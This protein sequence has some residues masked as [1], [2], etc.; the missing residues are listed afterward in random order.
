L[1]AAFMGAR[2]LSRQRPADVALAAINEE[3]KENG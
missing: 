1:A 2:A 3:E